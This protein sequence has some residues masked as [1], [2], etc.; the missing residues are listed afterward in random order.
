MTRPVLHLLL[1]LLCAGC[2]R[3][4]E[5]HCMTNEEC[6]PTGTCQQVVGG[7]CSY[8]D[9]MCARGRFSKYAGP[10]A[11][12]CVDTPGG[13][14]DAPETD[15]PMAGCPAGFVLLPGAP[16][17]S[18]VYKRL[19]G[20]ATWV[21]QHDACTA[22]A[23]RTYLA[24]PDDA[25]ELTGIAGIAGAASF[26]IGIDDRATEG[27]YVRSNDL[28]PATFLPW[29]TAAGEPDNPGAGDGQDCVVSTST[30]YSTEDCTGAAANRAAA[31]ECEPP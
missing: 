7:Y 11:N 5:F 3:Q 27:A 19:P 14:M 4:V 8:P 18:H 2:M 1:A 29:N 20:L 22:L 17:G 23:P 30:Q 15:G 26:W 24:V 13:G 12:Q 25:A 9:P 21:T 10:Y 16:P 28:M 6:G 31:C